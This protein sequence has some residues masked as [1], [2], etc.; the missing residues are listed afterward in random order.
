M[1][2]TGIILAAGLLSS[3]AVGK[4]VKQR[5]DFAIKDSHHVPR[6]WTEVRRPDADQ[7]IALRI[8]LKQGSFSEL[9]RQ[10]YEVSDPDHHRYGHHLKAEDVHK[11]LEPADE[12]L[13]LVHEWLA[14]Y[15]LD[16]SQLGYTPAR[17]WVTVTLPVADVEE[18]LDT[19]YA[20]YRHDDGSELVRTPEWSLPLHLHD[21]IDTIQPTNSWFRSKPK[22]YALKVETLEEQKPTLK[23]YTNASVSDVCVWNS[24]TPTCLRTL[25]ET[26]DYQAQSNDTNIMGLCDYLGETNNRNDTYKFLTEYR[27]EAKAAAYEFKFD[28]I[29]NGTTAQVYSEDM[30]DDET[31]VEGNLDVQTML[32]IGWPTKLIAYTVG[33]SPPFNK[34]Q[35]TTSD[36]NEPY[37]VW[38]DTVLSMSDR[39]IA[40]V[41]S[42]SYDDDEQ[43]VPFSYA[44]RVC[45]EMAQLGARGVSLFYASGDDG[46]GSSGDCVTNDGRN[47]STFLPEFPS[48]CPFVT[49]VGSTMNFTPEVVAHSSSGY[50]SGGG[51]SS[52]FSRPLYQ[53]GIV[54]KYVESLNGKYA[55]Y[56]NQE[57]RGYPDL[58]A[59]GYK[60]TEVWDN[61]NIL[62]SG[63]SAAT[64]TITA[65]F[66]LVN[67]ALLA[68]G[69]ST[70]GFVN[71]WLYK[72][73]HKA[74]TDITSGSA[75]GCTELADGLGFP[76]KKGWDAV[77]GFGTPRFKSILEL[78]CIGNG[79]FTGKKQGWGEAR[80]GDRWS[81]GIHH[82]W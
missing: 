65:I 41:I 62:V 2:A 71:P 75:V 16:E 60:Y 73:G 38:L 28:S 70:M 77:T 13:D 58:A 42:T 46:V 15:G 82:P 68:A 8:G 56:Y 49:S 25:Y 5:S 74:F 63:T 34:D 6:K 67:D 18:M 55:G 81:R 61:R 39:S 14:E 1:K 35:A 43:T 40:K 53:D 76:A 51:F 27:P 52:Y 23:L 37:L 20:V 36:T 31:G 26:I 48:S 9:E 11:L 45:N 59:Q 32:G 57:G 69:K 21:H 66:A 29:A 79:S 50:A 19:K 10:L 30:I 4:P 3:S 22:A 7:M 17:D 72:K 12:T 64:P 33:G 54:D 24:V 47:R 80:K 44:S 78:L